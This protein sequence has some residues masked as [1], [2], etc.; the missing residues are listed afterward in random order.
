MSCLGTYALME[1]AT[2]TALRLLGLAHL[3]EEKLPWVDRRQPPFLGSGAS[4]VVAPGASP[5]ATNPSGGFSGSSRWWRNRGDLATDGLVEEMTYPGTVAYLKKVIGSWYVYRV[6][7]GDGQP[8]PLPLVLP[9]SLGDWA[10]PDTDLV[11]QLD[12]VQG[13]E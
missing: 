1:R 5:T 6:L 8:P 12:T 2:K 9:E 3:S 11:G 10:R 4:S 7:Y 13:I